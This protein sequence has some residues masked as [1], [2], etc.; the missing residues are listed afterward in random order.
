[1]DAMGWRYTHKDTMALQPGILSTTGKLFPGLDHD[2]QRATTLTHDDRDDRCMML[3]TW[4]ILRTG[5]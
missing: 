2:G 1:M 5:S 4:M 3:L